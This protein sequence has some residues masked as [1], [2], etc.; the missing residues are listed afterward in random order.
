MIRTPRS[1]LP[2]S[3]FVTL[4]LPFLLLIGGLSSKGV[5]SGEV[6]TFH[7]FASLPYDCDTMWIGP[8]AVDALLDED[9]IRADVF[10]K[11]F[12]VGTCPPPVYRVVDPDMLG[13]LLDPALTHIAGNLSM[14][15]CRL[16]ATTTTS[17]VATGPGLDDVE[18]TIEGTL[19]R[20]S[21]GRRPRWRVL[22]LD[23]AA[24]LWYLDTG[25]LGFEV[26]CHPQNFW[27]HALARVRPTPPPPGPY[28][29]PPGSP[30]PGLKGR[31]G[32]GGQ[33]AVSDQA[34]DQ[35]E[36][37]VLA[38]PVTPCPAATLCLGRPGSPRADFLARRLTL[39][40]GKEALGL[41]TLGTEPFEV[42]R[43]E[44]GRPETEA[45]SWLFP[46]LNANATDN[47]GLLDVYSLDGFFRRRESAAQHPV[48]VV[49]TVE[50]LAEVDS[51]AGP[52]PPYAQWLSTTAFPGFRFQVRMTP[53]G[54][55]A[56]RP[57]VKSAA[58]LAQALCVGRPAA[59]PAQVFVRLIA[60]PRGAFSPILA[61]FTTDTVEVWIEQTA[62]R[63]VR[64][65]RLNGTFP[66]TPLLAG[67]YDPNGF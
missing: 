41:I 32:G 31:F 65:Y 24:L 30:G 13:S 57:G 61:K 3:I 7:G 62:R 38:V 60:G 19:V 33:R 12:R 26:G 2:R 64:Y 25:P 50:D 44:E 9:S 17:L 23:G 51:E 5:A 67:A 63:Q 56:G 15:T 40:D 8:V 20:P 66:G 27:V 14:E 47:S 35:A 21:A 43:L 49:P 53:L 1:I 28:R 36:A 16:S 42:W 37:A 45:V 52:A 48:P 59:A 11:G 55:V 6:V 34:P 58:C 18:D 39:L 46:A 54:A 10:P 22:I 4:L 29:K